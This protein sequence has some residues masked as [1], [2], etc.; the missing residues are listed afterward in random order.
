MALAKPITAPCPQKGI[1]R[2]NLLRAAPAVGLA[3]MMSSAI[4]A[5]A[6]DQE[7]PILALFRKWKQLRAINES[8]SDEHVDRVVEELHAIETQIIAHAEQSR[9]QMLNPL[10]PRSEIEL[11]KRTA[12]AAAIDSQRLEAALGML[13]SRADDLLR[14]EQ[15]A[16]RLQRYR[17]AKARRDKAAASISDRFPALHAEYLAM[18]QEIMVCNAMVDD[19]NSDLPDEMQPLERPEG[20]ARGFHDHGGYETVAS[21]RTLRITQTMLPSVE[22]S[23]SISWPPVPSY[24]N[25][26]Q[27]QQKGFSQPQILQF[28]R[29]LKN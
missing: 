4:P 19:V 2:R 12:E 28:F 13:N 10:L 8:V 3:A 25:F 22:A 14:V 11:A 7:G 21:F 15:A 23:D 16:K 5:Q 27:Q 20:L 6:A 9:K 29:R 24:Q 1:N 18:I 26:V 17:D